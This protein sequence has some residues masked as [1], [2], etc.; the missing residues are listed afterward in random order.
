MLISMVHTHPH[1]CARVGGSAPSRRPSLLTT[2]CI[3]ENQRYLTMA[4]ACSS[5]AQLADRKRSLVSGMAPLSCANMALTSVPQDSPEFHEPSKRSHHHDGNEPVVLFRVCCP[6]DRCGPVIGKVGTS[7]C[8]WIKRWVPCD[9][10]RHLARAG[11]HS[12]ARDPGH[13]GRQGEAGRLSARSAGAP[14]H[15]L[16]GGQV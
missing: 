12:G 16:L 6:S 9:M 14:D 2:H 13:D 11:R 1:Q 15:H 10:G 3:E 4:D 8:P 5:V 7:R